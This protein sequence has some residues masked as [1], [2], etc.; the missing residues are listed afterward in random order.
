LL[1]HKT[2]AA[3]FGQTLQFKK[4]RSMTKKAF[5]LACLTITILFLF[6]VSN[7]SPAKAQT[8]PTKT[9]KAC[10]ICD[11]D[12]IPVASSPTATESPQP[13]T[14]A[15]PEAPPN[16][17]TIIYMFWGDGC[18]HC[19]AAKPFLEGLVRSSDQVELRLFEVWYAE[20][21]RELFIQMAASHGFEPRSVP[22]FFIGE[23]YWEG[24]L[25]QIKV[26]IQAAV[27]TCLQNGCPDAG[28]GIIPGIMADENGIGIVTTPTEIVLPTEPVIE[29][30]LATG[31]AIPSEDLPQENTFDLP[32]IGSIDLSSQSLFISTILISFVDGFNPCSIW[33]LT[34]LLTLTLH[35]GSRKKVLLIGFIF[36]TVST[37]VYGLFI[38][39]LFT[40]FTVISFV[41]WVQVAVAL[42]AFF[43]ALV[44]IKD[45]FWYKEGISFTIA[46][47]KK[48]GI[49]KRMRKLMDAGQSFWGL[50]GGTVVLA[51]GVSLVEFSCTAGFPVLWTNLLVSQNV[52]ALT[53]VLL[54]LVYMIVYQLDEMGIFLVAVFTMRSSKLEEKHGRILKL[55]GGVLMLSLALVMLIN[56]HLMNSLSSSLIIF[57]IA[58]GATILILLVHRVLL[59]KLGIHI[60]TEFGRE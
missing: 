60:G 54:L 47:D 13:V 50:V 48:P 7:S 41:G 21:N 58:F 28:A 38:A 24:Y 16:H 4:G 27:N 12:V 3:E 55:I 22:T 10:H 52:P 31:E 59:P 26:Q 45:Y 11:T 18:P 42:V 51:A 49:F 36:L 44:N 34:M 37:A 53:F 57:G 32:I 39:G 8:A 5:W 56:P 29:T 14:S 30:V 15:T 40:M 20:E 6:F 19:E 17:K 35:T 25:D 1:K 2:G 9:I 33:V 46:D 23:Q 43:F